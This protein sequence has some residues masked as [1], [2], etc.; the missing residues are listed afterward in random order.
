M[1]PNASKYLAR[2]LRHDPGKI[3]LALD[4]QGWADVAELLAR[5]D[6]TPLDR[7]ALEALVA[8]CPKRRYAFDPTGTRIRAS[9]G[10]ST[11]AVALAHE[12][13]VPPPVLYHGTVA[14]ALPAIM[15]EGL[16]PM[17]RHHVHL[18]AS[19]QTAT[20]VGARRGTPVVLTVDAAGLATAGHAFYLAANGVWLTDHVPPGYVASSST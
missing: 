10:H 12:P 19:A 15:A 13:R 8:A 4:D 20:Q 5:W 7:P 9:Q 14:A 3:G 18:S 11:P 6:G 17:A 16:R 1:N 2:L